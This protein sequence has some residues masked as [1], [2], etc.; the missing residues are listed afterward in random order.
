MGWA[1]K[2]YNREEP[3]TF[4]SQTFKTKKQAERALRRFYCDTEKYDQKYG[5]PLQSGGTSGWSRSRAGS[6]PTLLSSFQRRKHDRVLF[7]Q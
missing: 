1:I 2:F 6:R 7:I 3:S 5:L 4:W